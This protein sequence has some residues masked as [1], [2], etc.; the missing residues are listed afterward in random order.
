MTTIFNVIHQI[1][2]QFKE[3]LIFGHN[4]TFTYIANYFSPSYIGN[5]P[6]C[7]MVA[8]EA[9]IEQWKDLNDKTARF[10]FFDYPKQHA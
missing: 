9:D 2:E 6:T 3:V 7:G 5:V 1:D 8:V 10:L 4:P